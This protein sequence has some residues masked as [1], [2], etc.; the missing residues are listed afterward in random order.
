MKKVL[1][2]YGPN[3]RSRGE[4]TV[5]FSKADSAAKAHKDYNGVNVDNRPMKVLILSLKSYRTC[6]TTSR[7]RSWAGQP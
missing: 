3:G 2:A 5:T 4:A 7:S 1:L 6:L